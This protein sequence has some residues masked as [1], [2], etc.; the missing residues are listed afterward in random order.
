VPP[1]TQSDKDSDSV[2]QSAAPQI[3]L[4]KGG[5]AIRGIGEKFST[6]AM[7]GMGSLS[8]PIAVSPGRSG[9]G[10]QLSLT[11]DSGAGNGVFG[12]GWSLSLPEISRKTAKGIPQYHDR[13]E[14]DVFILSGVEDL[15]P[16]LRRD[17]AG[18]WER[19]SAERDGYRIQFYRP[20]IEGLF[21]RIEKWTRTTDG[22][23]YWRSFT[24]DNVLTVYGPGPESRV[25]DPDQPRHVFQWMIAASYDGKGNAVHYEYAAENCLGVDVSKPSERRR[26]HTANRY[27]K[28]IKYG[29]RKPLQCDQ[30]D[31]NDPGWMFEVVFDFGEEGYQVSSTDSLTGLHVRLGDQSDWPARN[32][33][34][35]SYRSGFEVRTHRLCRRALM[36][37]HFPVEL[38]EPRSLVRS[39]EFQYNE[40]KL[41][42]LLTAAVQSGHTRLAD[43]TYLKKSL[44]RLDL[45]YAPSP[46]EDESPGPFEIKEADSRNLPEGIDGANYRW[47]DLN[48]EG[49]SGVLAEQDSGWYYKPNLGDGRFGATRLVNR[50]PS[51]GRLTGG[52]QQLMDVA[53]DGALDL[54][55]FVPGSAGFYA[56]QPT[57]V[58]VVEH[59]DNRWGRFRPFRAM[60]VLD[61]ND[62]NLRFVDLTGD[63]IADVLVTED[64]ALRWHPSLQNAGFGTAVRIPAPGDEND[65]PRV[66]FADRTQSIY[67]ADMSGDGLTDIVRIR[68]GEL[69]YWPNLGYGHFGP[70]VLMDNSPWFDSPNLFNQQ[71]IRLSDTDGSGTTDILYLTRNGIHVY[72]NESGNGWSERKILTGLPAAEPNS[73]SVTDFLGHGTACLVWS[74]PLPSFS[75]RPL[76]YVDL[77]RGEKPHLLNRVTNNLGAETVIQYASS[78]EFYLADKA[79][80]HPWVTRLPFPVHVVK[81]VETFDYVSRNRFVA[82][83]SYHHGYYD[84]VEREFRGFGRVDRLDTEEFGSTSM[85]PSA[86]NED[87]AW[88]VPPVLTKTWYH[89]GVFLG[90]D[91]VSRHLAHEYFKAPGEHGA[92][93]LDDT[94][95]P[96]GLNPEQAREACRALKGSTLRQEVYALDRSEESARPYTAAESNSTIRLVQPRGW[97]RHCVFFA[98]GRESLTFNYERKLYDVC[99]V[100]RA[101]PRVAHGLTLEVDEYG[102]VL[103]SASVG[104]GRLF[105]DPSPLLSDEDRA[106]QAQ[107]QATVNENRYTNAV[108]EPRAYRTPAL[109][110]SRTFE[111]IH[112]QPHGRI[113]GFE[114]FRREAAR[115]ADLPF[116]DANAIGATG[117]GPYKRL[118][119]ESRSRYRSD[120]LD[121]LLAVGVLESQELPGEGYSL[122]LTAGLIAQ[123]YRDKLPQPYAGVL[124]GDCGY[125]DL[126]GDGRW[127]VP[128]GRVFFSSTPDDGE[129]AYAR[130]H[131]YLPHRFE[132]PFGNVAYA[133]YDSHDLAPVETRDP[134][135]NVVRAD[136]DYR[137][138]Q[139]R[140]VIDANGNRSEA[141]FDALG[142]LAG[143]AVMGKEEEHLGDSLEDFVADLP[144]HVIL[145]H[146]R[147]PLV[148][149]HEILG[150]ATARMVYDLFAFDRTRREPQPKPSVTYGL[151]RETHVSDLKAGEQPKIQ[152]SFSYSDGL[153]REVQKKI[154]AEPGPTGEPR[155]VG[156]GWTIFNNKGKP[157]RQYEPFFSATQ[158]FEFAAKVGVTPTLIYDPAERV[159]AKLNPNHSFEKTVFDP[160]RQETWDSNDTLFLNPRDDRDIGA[161]L[162]NIPTEEYLPTWYEQ[163]G[164]GALGAAEESAAKKTVL[165]AHTPSLAFDDSLGRTFLSIAHN[166]FARDGQP[167]DEFHASRSDLDI[168]GNQRSVTDA[169][170]R[171]IM[172]YAYDVAGTKIHQNSSD[173]GERWIVNDIAKKPILAFD[174]REHRLR[175]EYDTLRRPTTLFVRTGA[176]AEKLA[177]RAEY[178][179]N[180]PDP[181]AHNLRGK[182]YRQFDG[183]GIV[184]T[185]SYD[186]KGNFLRSSRQML[187]DY[188]DEID[189]N[190][191]PA[192]EAE[193]FSS[194][195]SYDALNRPVTLT[196]PD[197]SVVKP[198]YNEANLLEQLHV[199]LKGPANFSPFVTNIDYDAKGQRELIEH[200]NGAR[201]VT[202]YDPLTFRVIHLRTTRVFDGA[203]LQDLAYAY[204]PIGNISSIAD[205]AQQTIYYKNQVV[206]ASAD[207]IYDAVYRL[208]KAN[209]REHGGNPDA[210][211]TS[212]NDVPRVHLPLPG[213]GQA[214]RNYRE[215]YRYDF[216][217]NILEVLHSAG[218]DGSWR[219]HY[220]YGQ[221]GSNNRL[222]KTSVG[223]SEDHYTYDP[224]GN[225]TRMQHLPLMEWDFMDHLHATQTQIVNSGQAETTYYV[226]DSD[227]QRVRKV[228]DG[229][230]GHRRADRIYL[231]G[232][233]MY[234]EY[235]A[236]GAV[237]LGRTTL[238]VMDD[239]RRVALVETRGVET[240]IR[241]Q[242]DNHLGSAC[243]E[244]DDAAAVIT[245]EEY[246]PY[247]ST[248]YQAGRTVAEV[249]LKRYRFTGKERDGE[250]GLS[251]HGARYYAPWLGRWTACDPAGFVDGP[252]LF[253]YVGA[254]PISSVDPTGTA[255]VEPGE[256]KYSE[257]IDETTGATETYASTPGLESH[258]YVEFRD[259]QLT[260]STPKSKSAPK[261]SN[262]ADDSFTIAQGEP[263]DVDAWLADVAAALHNTETPEYKAARD[264]AGAERARQLEYEEELRQEAEVDKE[265][266]GFGASLIPIYGSG[267]SA[268]VHFAHG[269]Y[270]RGVVYTA[271]AISDV[272]LVKSLVVSGGKILLKGAGTAFAGEAGRALA[273]GAFSEGAR[274][275]TGLGLLAGKEIRVSERG[276]QMI[277]QHL[278]RFGSIP[279]NEAMLARLRDAL[280]QGRRITGADASFY[281]HEANEATLMGRGIGYDAAHASAL[282]KYGVSPFSVYHPDVIQSLPNQ[283]NEN[284]FVFWGIS[285]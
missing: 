179:E 72:L 124:H 177:E 143:T 148:N 46:L 107:L 4:P 245:Y 185:G 28:R 92:S 137:V 235:A 58:P 10:P 267:K 253:A 175:R 248:S 162:R 180:Q 13:E 218:T 69:C 79:A 222:T 173:A 77:M 104:Y 153:G 43:Q 227:G 280:A 114:E 87:G 272:F 121:R 51:S 14:S 78:T 144:E 102:N 264:I 187:A 273:T 82:T 71:Q 211:E 131:F 138:L 202:S 64:V 76:R 241:Y 19:D 111:L 86:V 178:G 212:W 214:M 262:K 260:A 6:N 55:D 200:G 83:S 284:W 270:G 120:S 146:I 34:F 48:G 255:A 8:V 81:R 157:V 136:L 171:V 190:A 161:F 249:G 281:L 193:V 265:L 274:G 7:T 25:S 160:W 184:T 23:I 113:F 192:L 66:V 60:P 203:D 261:S 204:D 206:S 53:G 282:S 3:S 97:N 158:Q 156:S 30:H 149:P 215:Q 61:W 172:T 150:N 279:E 142:M 229:A 31:S 194:E 119:Q 163:R 15:V 271:L 42:A 100:L 37:H 128:S 44:P 39:T 90:A 257:S 133:T 154:Q 155:W 45:A 199:S 96:E 181:A 38:G 41:G 164:N 242:F 186:F 74:S 252:S 35:S 277:E 127:W 49:I 123:V 125:V 50:K 283:F 95:L 201:T 223:Q 221:I 263:F 244:L 183:A 141:A 2:S 1:N 11:Y 22:D 105:P 98:H 207:Y 166:R 240:T 196:A 103:K 134:I 225:M 233:E 258:E 224:D 93:H 16:A 216:V 152:H 24:K 117:H 159:V 236:D 269:N 254:N 108:N 285:K 251:Y 9:F 210:P 47:V 57:E 89:T 250:T 140:K 228:T 63:G 12:I 168:Q 176:G 129:L 209:G 40:K 198:A 18:G 5:G 70:K 147:D 174:S 219:R 54:V 85:F 65:G 36:F 80:G 27:L 21:A 62:S 213:D 188:R 84:G 208:L 33:P 275:G 26:V 139:P 56:G 17:A 266:P 118:F 112:L 109:A 259:D 220:E 29:N 126:D 205:S 237:T 115:A 145:E 239:K 75:Q 169:L 101:D 226:Y 116:E 135:G 256:D 165:H 167:H 243:L 73:V 32:D 232:F 246:Y 68:N 106:K 130:Q 247:G 110:E 67:L 189:W 230:T 195:T 132:D 191:S 20:R 182:M 94:L 170:G 276:L 59:E 99:G 88:R 91:R 231:G 197:Q 151:V 268:Y 52:R 278:T 122:A 238:H 217:G 234:R